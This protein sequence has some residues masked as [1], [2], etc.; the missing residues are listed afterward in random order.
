METGKELDRLTPK[1]GMY[2]DHWA[3]P[4]AQADVT[5]GGSVSTSGHRRSR[6]ILRSAEGIR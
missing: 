3:I 6:D 2:H 5:R 4:L 1:A